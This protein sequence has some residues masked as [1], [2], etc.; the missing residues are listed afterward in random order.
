MKPPPL[1]TCNHSNSNS[2][3]INNN[4]TRVH[5]I[6]IILAIAIVVG[7]RHR[8]HGYHPVFSVLTLIPV[9]AGPMSLKMVN[10]AMLITVILLLILMQRLTA[11]LSMVIMV[12]SR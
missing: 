11:I 12:T 2:N 5:D 9:L 6:I 10:V 7:T 3:N 4:N 1:K 8:R